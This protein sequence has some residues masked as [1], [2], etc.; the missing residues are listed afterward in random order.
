MGGGEGKTDSIFLYIVY[1]MSEIPD[2]ST[3]KSKLRGVRNDHTTY[4]ALCFLLSYYNIVYYL[5]QHRTS[6]YI[7]TI[8]VSLCTV[9]TYVHVHIYVVI[10]LCVWQKENK[11]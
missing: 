10:I 3:L 7:R 11:I 4:F 2:Y 1:R 9:R 6:V 8:Y 5:C